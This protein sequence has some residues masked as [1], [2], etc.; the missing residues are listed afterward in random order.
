MLSLIIILSLHFVII[1]G[2]FMDPVFQ[3]LL[4]C[5]LVFIA[6]FI[7][8]IA[9]G[10]G[11]ISV[12]AYIISGVPVHAAIGTNKMSSSMG[13]FW[14]TFKFAKD[15]FIPWKLA[16]SCV[17]FAFI[18]STIGANIALSLDTRTFLFCMLLLIPITGAYVLKSKSLIKQKDPLSF[19]K[20]ITLSIIISTLVGVYDGFYGPGTGTF[21][22]LLLT[23]LAH[24]TLKQANGITKVINSTTNLAALVIF[25]LNGQVLLPLGII[26]GLFGM[27]GNHLGAKYFSGKGANGVR[28][29]ILIVLVLFFL[30]VIY[31]LFIQ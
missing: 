19:K 22:I 9:G 27:L 8:A 5:P 12:P 29:I 14:A 17:L 20:T 24:V 11:L 6:G 3:Y 15:G 21:L 4:I 1:Q 2:E 10:G 13:T 26:A 31:E 16:L 28:P 25:L 7:D 23:G 18:G 30:R